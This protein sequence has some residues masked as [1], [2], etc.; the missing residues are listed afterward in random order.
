MI[1]GVRVIKICREDEG[2][3]GMRFFWPRWPSLVRAMRAADADVYYQNGA[4]YVTGQVAGWCRAN[5]RKFVYSVASDKDVDA[6]CSILES[7]RDRAFYRYGLRHADRIIVQTPRQR[8]DV[9]AHF[10]HRRARAAHAL[11][12]AFRHATTWRST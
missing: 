4:E 9:R 6:T 12:R 7:R 1:D 11:A 10:G 5:R 3:P 8:E 2:I